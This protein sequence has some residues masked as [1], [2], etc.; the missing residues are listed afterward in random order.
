MKFVYHPTLRK[1]F[2]L[3]SKTKGQK[4][5]FIIA[6]LKNVLFTNICLQLFIIFELFPLTISTFLSQLIN[7][8]LGYFLYSREVFKIRKIYKLKFFL[9]YIFL[10]ILLWLLNTTGIVFLSK[11]GLSKSIAAIFLIP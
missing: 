1:I 4:R 9:K 5:L 3:Y 11:L 8:F 10:M 6:G 2:L 7:M